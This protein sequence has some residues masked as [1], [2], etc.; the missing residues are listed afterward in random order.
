MGSFEVPPLSVISQKDTKHV[1]QR[2]PRKVL[3]LGSGGLQIGQAGE[4]D[5]SGSQAIKALKEEGIEVILIN[6]NI[7]TVQTAK[8]LADKVYFLPVTPE[9][10]EQ[11]IEK[12]APDGL[13]LQFGG[14]TAL[15]C[16]VALDN[17][18]VLA[19][20]N[21]KVLGTSVATIVATEDRDEFAAKLTEI[22]EPIAKSVAASNI[23]DALFAGDQIGYPVISRA[24][25]SLGGLGSGFANNR[26]ELLELVEKSFATSPQVLIERSMKGWKEVEYEVV[27]DA[28]D[29]C[30]TVCNME[31]FDPLGIHTGDSI[32]VAPS[33]T[34][35]DDE[36]HMLRTAAIRITRH[37]GVVGEC[38]VQYALHATSRQYCVIEVNPRLSRSSALASK[39]T[40][41][42]L[43]FVAAKIA[44]GKT[45]PELRNSV[46]KI[47]SACF[48]PSLDYC[49]VKIPRWDIRKFARANAKLGSGMKSVGEVMAV[50]RTF[51]E[52]FQKALRMVDNSVQGFDPKEIPDI[53]QI[54]TVPT[55]Q[56]VFAIAEALKRG[57]SVEK[58]H[59]MTCIDRWFLY[60]LKHIH[61]LKA[62]IAKSAFGSDH[63]VHL[64]GSAKKAGF[65]DT[66]I[67][68]TMGEGGPSMMDVRNIRKENGIVPVVKQIDT[69][70]A[71]WPAQTNY[72]YTTYNGTT[73]DVEFGDKGIVVLGGGC[74]CIGN[75][76]E[77]DYTAVSCIRGLRE[78]GKKTIMINYNPETVS[79]DYDES[80]RL[81]F[82]ELSFERVMD[83]CDMEQPE[84]LVPSVGGQIPNNLVMPLAAQG[85]PIM[86]TPADSIDNA[87]DRQRFSDLCDEIGVDQP[88]WSVMSTLEEA[89]AF[90]NRVGYPV[91][92]RPSYV[93]SGAAMRVVRSS[94]GLSK[95]LD[96]AVSVSKDH[97]VVISKF[98]L[99]A[100][101]IEMDGVGNGGDVVVSAIH[102]HIEQAGVHSGDA[103]LVL[104]P[105]ELP[106][107]LKAKVF[108]N[109]TA[110]CKAL[111]IT[112]PFNAQFIVDSR[113]DTV[114]I[115]EC[116]VRA[117]RSF[118]FVSKILGVDFIRQAVNA[119][120][121]KPIDPSLRNLDLSKLNFVGVKVPNFSFA[122]LADADP[123]LGVEMASTG[124]VACYGRNK[125]EAFLKAMLARNFKLPRKNIL[126]MTGDAANKEAFLP[127][128]KKLQTMG[129]TLFATPGSARH[130]RDNGV[131]VTEVLMEKK[132]GDD[133]T[134]Q[135]SIAMLKKKKLD[136][137]INFPVPMV[138]QADSAEYTRRYRVRRA[139]IDFSV[140]LLNNLQV[141]RT[142]VDALENVDT[143]DLCGGDEYTHP[144][145]EEPLNVALSGEE[146]I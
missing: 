34:L 21:V 33:Q 140:S 14:Q 25:F 104:P 19:R 86:G 49:V 72:L 69:L 110:I 134:R 38:N 87:E 46:N 93:L 144:Y 32:V 13:L 100:Q 24:A 77:F 51:E 56:R 137:V 15:N 73:N 5:Y 41:Y 45:L 6:P 120:L 145:D 22:G 31:N 118:P 106:A 80:D 127:S 20:H 111:N 1:K 133:D 27:R 139:A 114:K 92:V 75:S 129:F 119:M 138:S 35:D 60:K 98:L 122:R 91:L 57:Y 85:V 43:A 113:D 83:I 48:E 146:K 58:L 112:G 115:I 79:T 70:A 96:E 29:N 63:F 2:P 16:G 67:S 4:F 40:G 54:M 88:A 102:E 26:E 132:S 125:H 95:F 36:Y 59:D 116:N 103:S 124:E 23:E 30:I 7:A 9:F 84:G 71:E 121:G 89:F 11:I 131:E 99:G 107:H 42:P 90:A 128:A 64:L 82:D 28:E 101:E 44:L 3:L 74:Y 141:A 108:E 12:E 50:G 61:D 62:A 52:S 47:T 81:Y 37:L 78:A 143:F 53:D 68:E 65:S 126:L 39:A 8:G 94:E 117:S 55:D 17:S 18:G 66:Q 130:L 97:P 10:V 142:L 109:G 136:L 76:V 105:E 135:C 123:V